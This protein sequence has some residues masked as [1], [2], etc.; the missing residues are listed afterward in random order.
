MK[1]IKDGFRP[2]YN[3]FCIFPMNSVIQSALKDEKGIEDADGVMVYG[4]VDHFVG[5]TL[6]FI[7]LTK[8]IDDEKYS[9]IKLPD[10][11]RFFCR[12]D[13]LAENEF[14]FLES[15]D[16][17]LYEQFKFKID[18]I[19]YFYDVN[20]GVTKSRKMAFLDEFRQLFHYDDV[21]VVLYKSGLELEGVWA[22]IEDL[23]KGFF[24]GTLMNEPKQDFGVSAGTRIAFSVNENKDKVRSLIADLSEVKKYEADELKGGKILKE[25][26]GTFNNNSNQN[27]MYS[28]LEILKKSMVSVVK[29]E[30]GMEILGT[31]DN[32]FYLPVYSS[33]D[34]IKSTSEESEKI[35]APFEETVKLAQMGKNIA[36]IVVN[37]DTDGFIIPQAMLEV[38]GKME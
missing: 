7:A 6:E 22:R 9:F 25:A 1:Y 36:G 34:E 38:F 15:G 28:V 26:L 23:G 33:V 19:S 37:P 5:N 14:R 13:K 32:V 31:S 17:H 30:N 18:R 11:A 16:G 35:E 27:N 20:E 24:I 8:N 2:L 29:K 21:K 4:Y 12:A 3:N 10:D